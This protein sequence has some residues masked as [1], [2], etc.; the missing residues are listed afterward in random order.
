M[1][2]NILYNTAIIL[3]T[4]IV[5]IKATNIFYAN[6]IFSSVRLFGAKYGFKEAQVMGAYGA[7]YGG[8]EHAYDLFDNCYDGQ[9][10]K[11]DKV[12]CSKSVF[13]TVASMGF[14]VLHKK[15]T[16]A[17]WKRDLADHY[18]YSDYATLAGIAAHPNTTALYTNI[19][20][21]YDMGVFNDTHVINSY[22]A[23]ALARHTSR[24]RD[25][26]TPWPVAFTIVST[27][28]HS[29]VMVDVHTNFTHAAIT[30][31]D[32]EYNSSSTVKRDG[33]NGYR[34]DGHEIFIESK[35]LDTV[36]TWDEMQN[37]EHKD[38]DAE[39]NDENGGN[40]HDE[41]YNMWVGVSTACAPVYTPQLEFG[42]GCYGAYIRYET[43]WAA[44]DDFDDKEFCAQHHNDLCYYSV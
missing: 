36:T 3:A 39:I 43:G 34:T 35:S 16:G 44:E 32:V 17:W 11:V 42:D 8:V 26:G 6:F 19:D 29:P 7:G 1:T 30:L 41:G 5:G 21:L 12:A 22:N 28:P 40:L 15:L 14:A 9:G 10:N 31:H 25:L 20:Q 38:S 4:A 37:F 2:Y 23:T 24:K 27:G 33:N 13:E 18:G